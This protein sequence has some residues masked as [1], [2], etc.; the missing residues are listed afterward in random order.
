MKTNR[1]KLLGVPLDNYLPKE[2]LSEIETNVAGSGVKT[3]FAV[4]PEKIMRARRDLE[5]LSALEEADVLIPDGIG[6]VIGLRL[7]YGDHILRTTGIALMRR[8]LEVSNLKGYR[9]FIFGSEPDANREACKNITASYPSLNLVG[10][11]HGYLSEGEHEDLVREINTSAADILFVGLGSPKQ[12][13]W[14]HQY[15]KLLKVKI[16]MGV[17]G[18]LDVLAG[19]VPGAPPFVQKLG[20]E[21]LYRLINEPPRLKRQLVLPRFALALIKEK[22]LG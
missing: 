9:I 20:L 7:I 17:G 8:L 18:Y 1:R 3:I 2:F 13:K 15:K 5:L 4:N 21:W 6:T 14:I 22:F 11:Q 19:K 10:R 16:C 12:E